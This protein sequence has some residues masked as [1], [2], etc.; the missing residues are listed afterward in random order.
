MTR[1]VCI[2]VLALA[3][4]G[5]GYSVGFEDWGPTPRSVA[6]AVVDNRTFRQRV[7][8]PLTRAILEALAVHSNLRP[9]APGEADTT[10]EVEITDIEGRNLVGAGNT[11]VREGALDFRV[12]AVLRDRQSDAVLRSAEV[13]DRAEFRIDVG[14]TLETAQREAVGDLARKI[15]LA[16]EHDA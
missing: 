14:E 6:V 4:A 13:R 15:V 16:L 8:I 7:E 11:P 9:A 2:A 10:L 12:R 3:L 5:C 1:G